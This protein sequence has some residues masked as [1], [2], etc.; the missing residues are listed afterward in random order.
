M[1]P[2]TPSIEAVLSQLTI[3]EKVA[4]LSGETNWRT[5]AIPRLGI[6]AIKTSDGPNGVR[7]E[8]IHASTKSSCFPCGACM[9][10]TFNR[11]LLH[12]IGEE[13][14][15][16][17]KLK[18]AGVILGPTINIHRHPYGG[19]NFE[20]YSEDPVL[21]GEL[22]A[23]YVNGLQSQRI[24][25]SPK[26]FVCNECEE[27]RHQSN[28]IVDEKVLRE[29]YL[30]PFQTCIRKS[31][32]WSLMTAYNK[33]NGKWC[34]ENPFLLETI[35]RCEWKYDGCTMSDFG[36][37]YT[38]IEPIK[39]G[40]N[41]EMPGPSLHRGAKTIEALSQGKLNEADI[42][43]NI[44]QIINLSRK[45]GMDDENALEKAAPDA[46]T[47]VIIRQTATEGIVL[48]KNT[49]DV[50]PIPPK[51][52]FKIAVFGAPAAVPLVHGGGSP[53]LSSHYVIAP[54]QALQQTYQNVE[55]LY[56]VPIFRKIPSAPL[57]CMTSSS[58]KAGV[59]CHWYNGSR[60][61]E[62]EILHE[63][64]DTTR[65]L[66]IDS[67]ITG[68]E[69]EHCSRM[70]CTL[71]P[72]TSGY[73]TF[74]VTACGETH[75]YVDDE[76]VVSH[77]GFISTKVPHI[78]QPW[79]FEKR[80][81]I[82][83][84]GGQG[85]KVRIDTFSTVAPP[86]PPPAPQ[87]PPQATQVGF[88]ENL[89]TQD[90]KEL[91]ALASKSDVSIIFTGNNKEWESESFDRKTFHLSSE[92]EE[93]ISAVAGASQRTIVINQTG[94]PIAMPWLD[95]VD[96]VLQTWFAGMEV[97]NAVADVLSGQVSPSGRLPTTFPACISDVPSDSNFPID[98]N[99]DIRYA[100]G[101]AVG[102][103][104]LQCPGAKPPLFP[105]GYGLSY[106]KFDY[107][108]LTLS[109]GD[110][111]YLYNTSV[112]V[113]NVSRVPSKEVI[114]VYVDGILKAFEKVFIA[115]G[116]HTQVHIGLEKYAFSTWNA[117]A[118]SWEIEARDYQVEIRR[119]ALTVITSLTCTVLPQEAF[120]W[121]GL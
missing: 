4:L 72:K 75:I 109:K 3:D 95:K 51:T 68:L 119:D 52:S 36:G 7:G 81:S 47:S 84:N 96:A 28:S 49:N 11:D 12:N 6:K 117:E 43:N 86:P 92:Q 55:Y 5:P 116:D 30:A 85:Y 31:N 41:L 105:F 65:T 14:G 34:S 21:S 90:L 79:R 1:N 56:G 104:A 58:G 60:F 71:V 22:A 69:R 115:A 98:R 15:K 110:A 106:A 113:T 17:A 120:Q 80:A 13:L 37:V 87:I 57:D 74:G 53:S 23:A 108:D 8:A 112:T 70:E 66:V 18:N 61:G 59:D 19:R 25:A 78:M 64:L 29:L 97:G 62:N 73:H 24:A 89:G 38:D 118:K 83:M 93:M 20:S 16:E 10:A 63:R 50:L 40:L 114:Q 121:A 111:P 67:R 27:E 44:A 107:S 35:L 45:V 103:R 102:Y 39:C 99:L 46:Q 42:D 77:E 76:E 32:L 91:E 82:K 26:H 88:F 2:T 94:A 54:L 101:L 9:G 48:L 100:E 33:V